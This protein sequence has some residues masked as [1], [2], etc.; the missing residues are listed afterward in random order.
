LERFER[1]HIEIL[2]ACLYRPIED[3]DANTWKEIYDN[4]KTYIFVALCDNYLCSLA[5]MILREL[6]SFDKIQDDV[7]K[8]SSKIFLRA[9]LLLYSPESDQECR[10][11]ML[12]FLNYLK[13]GHEGTDRQES[14]RE[15]T[16]EILKEFSEKSKTYF[17]RSNL[18]EFMNNLA[19][20][21]R[22]KSS[23]VLYSLFNFSSSQSRATVP[24]CDQ[25]SGFLKGEFTLFAF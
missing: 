15:Y 22:G 2:A 6:F 25:D 18:V 14:F 4:L 1:E 23:F 11:N 9:L 3:Q 21:R 19:R 5:S 8:L 20:E 13:T 10:D 24:G 16:Y 17:L 7:M 12:Q